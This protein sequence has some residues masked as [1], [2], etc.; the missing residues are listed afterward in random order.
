MDNLFRIIA[1][2]AILIVVIAI[3]V[4]VSYLREKKL[5][6]GSGGCNGNCASCS[7]KKGSCDTK[8]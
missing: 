1:G 6:D 8:K 7:M 4:V 2:A 5:G 3:Y